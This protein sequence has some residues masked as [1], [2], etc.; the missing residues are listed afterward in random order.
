[1]IISQGSK[2]RALFTNNL[3]AD[4]NTAFNGGGVSIWPMIRGTVGDDT[5]VD[6]INN[7]ITGNTASTATSRG[8]GVFA[9]S[10]NPA[11]AAW[12]I[13]NN[14]IV[15][16]NTAP[17]D[18]QDLALVGVA[19]RALATTSII[20]PTLVDGADYTPLAVVDADPLFVDPA[21]GDYHLRAGSPA[22]GAGTYGAWV[23]LGGG[24]E[25]FKM[26]PVDDF[27]GDL[28][29]DLARAACCDPQL[30]V[31]IGADQYLVL[32][33]PTEALGWAYA[34]QPLP[35]SAPDPKPCRPLGVGTVATG[36]DDVNWRVRLP[37]FS[38]P[39][40]LYLALYAPAISDDY[41]LFTAEGTVQRLSEGLIP[42]RTA[43][44]GG[45]DVSLFGDV[46]AA[47]FP[48]GGYSLFLL[49]AAPGTLEQHYLWMTSVD[50]E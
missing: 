40:D 25:Y 27:E 32:P 7:T 3:I 39:V 37:A 44:S 17:S 42:W 8:G 38:G 45:I 2:T 43:A 16:G 15:R 34:A 35:V 19:V 13:L 9:S 23:S 30:G 4:N 12:V 18:G 1:L 31:D 46:P 26:A 50:M 29:P 36:G 47:I 6:L 14:C 41:W 20:G 48:P 22:I 21:M 33:V 11:N 10:S 5:E 49:A 24:W 28:R